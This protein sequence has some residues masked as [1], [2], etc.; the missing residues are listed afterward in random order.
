MSAW[1]PE[2]VIPEPMVIFRSN[3]PS[4]LQVAT[5]LTSSPSTVLRVKRSL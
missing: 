3:E 4:M 2:A 1:S 5:A